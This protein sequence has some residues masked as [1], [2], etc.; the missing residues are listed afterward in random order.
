MQ[1]SGN[2]NKSCSLV[3]SLIEPYTPDGESVVRSPNSNLK[4]IINLLLSFFFGLLNSLLAFI[5]FH[6]TVFSLKKCDA[7]KKKFEM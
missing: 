4:G 5:T 2:Y 3:N 6:F 7:L 1:L